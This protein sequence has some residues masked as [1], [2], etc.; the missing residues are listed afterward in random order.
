VGVNNRVQDTR[1]N[2]YGVYQNLHRWRVER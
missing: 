1:I 2:T